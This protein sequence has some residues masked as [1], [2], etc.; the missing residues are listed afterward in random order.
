MEGLKRRSPKACHA[1]R[2]RKVRCDVSSSGIPCT[3]CA[4]TK[5]ECLVSYAR[6]KRKSSALIESVIPPSSTRA[7]EV[8]T[9]R[10]AQYDN[11]PKTTTHLP[12]P[13]GWQ[14]HAISEGADWYNKP[15][16][17][18]A[19]HWTIASF[20]VLILNS[21]A[22]HSVHRATELRS[23]F[24]HWKSVYAACRTSALSIRDRHKSLNFAG[25]A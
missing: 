3:N 15:G 17:R 21:I 4:G 13:N 10:S 19:P 11:I 12:S 5:G 16:G 1:C 25:A 18:H 2:S 20:N 6:K 8:S 7:F 23:G 22:V 9:S 24:R 14:A